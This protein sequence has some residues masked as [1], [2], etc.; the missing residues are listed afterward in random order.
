M[1]TK[2]SY[3]AIV[4]N[5]FC[6]F[7]SSNFP[8]D[9]ASESEW[10]SIGKVLQKMD[11]QGCPKFTASAFPA[12]PTSQP[13]ASHA[14][15]VLDA[16]SLQMVPWAASSSCVWKELPD[17]DA[18]LAD[19]S[20]CDETLGDVMMSYKSGVELQG[21]EEWETLLLEQAKEVQPL[22]ASHHGISKMVKNAAL[23]QKKVKAKASLVLAYCYT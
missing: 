15:A 6:I 20:D 22:D 11:I 21:G 12:P 2:F 3:E 13:S 7:V 19:L 5:N 4:V 18:F 17:V 1:T 9:Q 8:L 23:K 16:S 10:I 14:A